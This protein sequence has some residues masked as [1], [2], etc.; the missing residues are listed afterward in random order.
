MRWG[1]SSQQED[2]PRREVHGPYAEHHGAPHVAVAA[3]V[4]SVLAQQPMPD[5][6]KRVCGGAV[7]GAAVLV[8]DA[9]IVVTTAGAF[10]ASAFTAVLGFR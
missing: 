5:A 7:V 4:A 10:T 3:T 1:S 9:V 6:S 2:G 8:R